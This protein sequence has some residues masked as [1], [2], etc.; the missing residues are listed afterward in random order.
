M[1]GK[2]IFA[3][4]VSLIFIAGCAGKRINIDPSNPVYKPKSDFELNYGFFITPDERK[5][6]YTLEKYPN[7]AGFIKPFDEI[8]TLE[9]FRKSEKQFWDIRDTDP[10]TPE[11]EFKELIDRRIQDIKNE[12]FAADSD[13]PGFRF[14][15]DLKSDLARVYLLWG[16]P[17]LCS[18]A[19]LAEGNYHSELM[20]WY[21]FFNGRPLFRFLF[22]NKYGRWQLFKSY[23]VI[24]GYD[25][26][27]NPLISPLKEI[28]SRMATTPQEL[29]EVWYELE[30]DDI[31]WMFRNALF[32]FSSYSD[33]VIEGGNNKDKFG[34][35]DPPEPAAL[36]A[37]RFK[38]TILGQPNI[39]EGT[40]LVESGYNSFIPIY[41]RTNVDSDNPTFLMIITLR[42]NVDWV[43]QDNKE[44]PYV[45][46]LNLRISFQN[47][48]TLKL[49]EFTTYYRFEL[50][51]EEF[52]KKDN[53]GM[54]VGSLVTRPTSLP[55][56]DGKKLGPTLGET[57]KQLEP[58]EYV[59]S[60]YLQHTLTK[61]YN[62]WRGEIAIK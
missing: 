9:E 50:S 61:K 7:L 1:A 59:V 48:K 39:P 19:K 22:Y 38:P 49:T 62:A 29:A 30:R 17:M 18:K 14:N 23:T 41:I 55:Y 58:G 25:D 56:F 60:M 28:S 44:K 20:V 15:G 6:G 45:A 4:L 16:A 42:K 11:N 46:N 54:L 35:L 5:E 8:D 24:L 10:N 12:I 27:F 2:R 43:K 47:K 53:E 13:I 21:Y 51:Q 40:E 3:V 57:L 26:L 36:T 32:E 37:K 31:E 33:W 34:A 52:D